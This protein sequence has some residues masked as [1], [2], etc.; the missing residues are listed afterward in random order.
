MDSTYLAGRIT[1]NDISQQVLLIA[2][3]L[4]TESDVIIYEHHERPDNLHIHFL[5]ANPKKSREDTYAKWVKVIVGGDNTSRKYSFKRKDVN[6]E[7]ISYMSKGKL[8]PVGVRSD[9]SIFTPAIIDPLKL[10]GYDKKD[11]VLGNVITKSKVTEWTMVQEVIA[12]ADPPG[13]LEDCV[14]T[15]KEIIPF[16]KKVR[17]KNKRLLPP[18]QFMEFVQKCKFFLNPGDYDEACFFWDSY[19]SGKKY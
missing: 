14:Y 15:T 12:L 10:K 11:K 16:A 2:K 5:V 3:L 9:N 1:Y 17:E 4:D 7:F 13:D 8:D 19:L 18:K 6:I